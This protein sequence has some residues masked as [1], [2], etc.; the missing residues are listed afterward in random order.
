MRLQ[1]F[2]RLES[3]VSDLL[4][5]HEKLSKEAESPY[6]AIAGSRLTNFRS[7]ASGR[8]YFRP[9]IYLFLRSKP[10]SYSKR[11]LWESEVKYLR[12]SRAEY[13]KHRAAFSRVVTQVESSLNA[14]GLSAKRLT[15]E[16]WFSLL[17]EYFNLSRSEKLP[18]PKL[19]GN[20]IFSPSLL[21]QL[22]LTDTFLHKDHL[23]IGGYLFRVITLKTLPEETSAS[24]IDVLL[25][26]PFHAWFSENIEILDQKKEY[27][28]LQMK[29]RLTH[30]MAAAPG[31]VTDMESESKLTHIEGLISELLESSERILACDLNVILWAKSQDELEEKSDEVLRAFKSMNQAEGVVE[32][33]P[34]FDAFMKA[35]PGSGTGLRPKK[36]KTS[37]VA[38]L[39]P[40]YSYWEGK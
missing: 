31:N 1:L 11:K 23:E 10:L 20:S 13:Q 37:N 36:M 6:P 21:S 25:K 8:A 16:K 19:R 17:Y 39:M 29:R 9:R 27:G 32:T 35:W 12:V 34:G 22:I 15:T 3:D 7:K 18:C 38:H 33:Y 30:S 14:S 28:R 4:L 26:L 40:L 24:L 5:A 2:Y